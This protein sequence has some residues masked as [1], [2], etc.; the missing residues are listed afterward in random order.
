MDQ[1][2]PAILRP[3]YEA[4]SRAAQNALREFLGQTGVDWATHASEGAF[5][6]WVWLRGLRVTTARPCQRLKQ[7]SVLVVP[8]EHFFYGLPEAWSHREECLRNSFAQPPE[9]VREGIRRLAEEAA[10]SL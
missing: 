10:R 6:L 4:R 9:V 3:F 5:F 1:Y 7:R 8:G 2:S